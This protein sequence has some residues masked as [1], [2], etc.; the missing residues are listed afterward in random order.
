[1]PLFLLYVIVMY[2][3][4]DVAI[5]V[6]N[7]VHNYTLFA[8]HLTMWTTS[9]LA[10][11]HNILSNMNIIDCFSMTCLPFTCPRPCKHMLCLLGIIIH[12]K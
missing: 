3:A 8:T 6:V 4:W 12:M 11:T 5:A 2:L 7:I 9:K 10:S 1:M